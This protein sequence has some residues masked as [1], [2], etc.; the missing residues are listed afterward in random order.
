MKKTLILLVVFLTA[1]Q[2]GKKINPNSSGAVKIIRTS[3]LQKPQK[4]QQ[5]MN[6]IPKGRVVPSKPQIKSEELPPPKPSAPAPPTV[7]RNKVDIVIK[8]PKNG[9]A[10]PMIVTKPMTTLDK[11]DAW[12][13]DHGVLISYYLVIFTGFLMFWLLWKLNNEKRILNLKA[14]K[15]AIKPKKRASTK[16][17]AK[18]A[19]KKTTA[20]KAVKK[21]AKKKASKKKP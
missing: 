8:E 6:V 13:S 2:G 17:T 1:C 5:A 18:K 10:V 14:S 9:P 19:A 12:I 20:K 3:E 15:Q 21:T 11:V 4:E 16:R 7:Q